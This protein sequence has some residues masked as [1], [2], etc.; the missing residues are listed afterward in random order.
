MTSISK[1]GEQ[2]RLLNLT[3]REQMKLTRTEIEFRKRLLGLDSKSVG[4]LS[5]M[6]EYIDIN[7]G[8]IVDAFYRRQ[9]AIKEI[10]LLIGDAETLS[11]LSASM[12]KYV[13]SLFAGEYGAEYVSSRLRIGQVH[14]RIGVSPK[15]YLCGIGTLGG[16]IRNAIDDYCATTDQEEKAAGL[17]D[18]MA[19]L[20]LFDVGLVFDTYIR[21]LTNEI[22]TG[23]DRLELHAQEL[24]QL[25]AE[26]THELE[27]LARRDALTGLYNQRSFFDHLRREAAAAARHNS[28]ISLAYLDIDSFKLLNDTEGHRAGDEVLEIVGRAI[29]RCIRET[30]FGCR[31]GGDEF[32]IIMPH[33]D[34]ASAYVLASRLSDDLNGALAAHAVSV[35]VGVAESNPVSPLDP[36]ELLKKADRIMYA[37]KKSPGYTI[38]IDEDGSES[39]AAPAPLRGAKDHKAAE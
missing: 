22:E 26:R 7:V 33:T 34:I 36:D 9:T 27:Q 20:I 21:S 10:E 37:A 4:E 3:L 35:S 8:D 24:E 1:R 11:R 14:K 30:D 28:P 29:A 16:L 23:R 5:L 32:A 12:K 25:V 13:R 38:A 18:T 31:Y 17:R 2:P 15:L 6:A 39:V 19:K